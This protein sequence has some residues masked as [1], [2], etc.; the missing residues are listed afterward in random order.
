MGHHPRKR[1]SVCNTTMEDMDENKKI[2]N[3][4]LRSLS[5]DFD[6]VK[7]K[8]IEVHRDVDLDGDV[9]L[10]VAVMFEGAR[11]DVDIKKLSSAVRHIRPKLSAIGEMAFPVLSFISEKEVG[12]VH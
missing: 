10:R 7:I 3:V 8:S 4:I 9:V 6:N 12:H 1:V 11:K 5:D 2:R